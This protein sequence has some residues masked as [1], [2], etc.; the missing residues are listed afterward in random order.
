VDPYWFRSPR[1]G[2]RFRVVGSGWSGLRVQFGPRARRGGA[3]IHVRAR[4]LNC[5]FALLPAAFRDP[6]RSTW[7]DVDPRGCSESALGSSFLGVCAPICPI[8]TRHVGRRLRT[9]T[10]FIP[11]PPRPIARVGGSGMLWD[12][13]LRA[14]GCARL[15]SPAPEFGA[16]V[17]RGGFPDASQSAPEQ[18]ATLDP[19]HPGREIV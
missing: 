18:G 8:R 6:R 7:I 19:R 1:I 12:G 14:M 9:R 5:R 11:E 10:F 3:G 4:Q 15:D 17:R 16:R 13:R 2:Y